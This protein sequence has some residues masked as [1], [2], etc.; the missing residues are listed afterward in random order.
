MWGLVRNF[1][2]HCTLQQTSFLIR[3]PWVTIGICTPSYE[4]TEW[5]PFLHS[6]RRKSTHTHT[7]NALNLK[8]CLNFTICMQHFCHWEAAGAITPSSG[9]FDLHEWNWRLCI[10]Q[11]APKAWL[12]SHL[13]ACCSAF[14]LMDQSL[15]L[16]LISAAASRQSPLPFCKYS[17]THALILHI[18]PKSGLILLCTVYALSLLWPAKICE[19]LCR[20]REP[21]RWD[22][23]VAVWPC[24]GKAHIKKK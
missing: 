8:T 21:G 17:F 16:R 7:H 12:W 10:A 24:T 3:S 14:M 5:C 19:N 20:T 4:W 1:I 15:V 18:C 9:C 6:L 23:E 2:C 13:W 11:I 22:A